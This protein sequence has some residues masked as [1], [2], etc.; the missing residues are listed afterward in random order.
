MLKNLTTECF[1]GAVRQ[2]ELIEVGLTNQFDSIDIDMSDM[3]DRAAAMGKKFACQFI[4]SAG[5][6]VACFDLSWDIAAEATAY[7]AQLQKLE[8]TLDLASEV[9]NKRC[10][11][12]IAAT[13]SQ[14]YHETFELVRQRIA[15]LAEPFAAKGIALGLMLQRDPSQRVREY[16]FM[17]KADELLTLIKL[18]G[19]KNVGL[20]LDA[21]SWRLAG[22]TLE[23][24]RKF[25][26]GQWV[27]VQLCD[28]APGAR[29]ADSDAT[30]R[31]LPDS[32][33]DAFCVELVK[34]LLEIG[35]E[36]PVAVTAHPQQIGES[37]PALIARK[38]AAVL[39]EILGRTAPQPA[40]AAS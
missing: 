3:L 26:L 21:C 11:L 15:Q 14:V 2:N 27:D 17:Q 37:K 24:L 25:A 7:D 30:A 23:G 1:R 20:A 28:P 40:E 39:Q 22:G 6:P 12:E 18:I 36:G 38:L 9:G 5:I 33:E 34:H 8:T 35:Y 29:F 10:R 32:S 31:C 16:Q 19:K 13:G 4:K